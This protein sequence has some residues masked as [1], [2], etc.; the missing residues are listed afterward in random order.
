MI[1]ENTNTIAQKVSN[2][3][4][5]QPQPISI[6]LTNLKPRHISIAT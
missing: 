4:T 5:N 1:K 2:L 6:I 3:S